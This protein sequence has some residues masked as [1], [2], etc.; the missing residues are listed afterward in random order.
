MRTIQAYG[1]EVTGTEEIIAEIEE[2]LKDRDTKINWNNF[3]NEDKFWNKN[4]DT[5]Y[6]VLVDHEN[7]K[8]LLDIMYKH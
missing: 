4:G 3:T 8:V 6:P 1:Y 7:K 2:N 5:S